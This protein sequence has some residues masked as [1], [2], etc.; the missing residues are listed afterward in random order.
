SRHKLATFERSDPRHV[1]SYEAVATFDQAKDAFA[2]TDAAGAPNQNA[3]TQNVHHAS[4]LGHRWRKIDFKSD[5]RRVYKVHRD[6]RRAKHS[7]LCFLRD[8]QQLRRK[9]KPARHH[10]AGNLTLTKLAKS[11]YACFWRQTFEI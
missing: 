6:H 8:G 5:S 11:L 1:I 9:V 10:Q 2:F 7:D 3:D 4:E